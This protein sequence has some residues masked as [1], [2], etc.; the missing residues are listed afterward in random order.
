[1]IQS[2]SCRVWYQ[3]SFILAMD[4]IF[5]RKKRQVFSL[6]RC[7]ANFKSL[8]CGTKTSEAIVLL[9]FQRGR[10]GWITTGKNMLDHGKKMVGYWGWGHITSMSDMTIPITRSNSRFQ[11]PRWWPLVMFVAV[12]APR[13]ESWTEDEV[14][15]FG[16]CE[17]DCYPTTVDVPGQGSVKMI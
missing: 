10:M 1:M 14:N 5:R 12:N 11:D 2:G 4:Q 9:F 17:N 6:N 8:V 13:K 16:K 15:R 7:D 3:A